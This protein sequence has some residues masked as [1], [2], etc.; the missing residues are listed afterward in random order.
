[1]QSKNIITNTEILGTLENAK[2]DLY[3]FMTGRK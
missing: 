1:M 3:M 2:I